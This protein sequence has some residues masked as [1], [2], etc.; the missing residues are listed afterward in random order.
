M[1]TP[2]V[3][4]NNIRALLVIKVFS[5]IHLASIYFHP[6]DSPFKSIRGAL[7]VNLSRMASAR[8]GSLMYSYH[9]ATNNCEIVKLSGESFRM[10]NRKTLFEKTNKHIIAADHAFLFYETTHPYL[11]K[12]VHCYFP[13][14][15]LSNYDFI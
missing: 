6:I 7:A 12:T 3:S 8:V 1:S 13:T 11:P 4:G 14:T 9:L 10:K 15:F 5:V 2:V